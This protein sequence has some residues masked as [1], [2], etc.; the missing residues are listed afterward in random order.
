MNIPIY[1]KRLEYAEKEDEKEFKALRKKHQA[2]SNK[3]NAQGNLNSMFAD[4]SIKAEFRK[5][6]DDMRMFGAGLKG[7]EMIIAHI[8][9]DLNYLKGLR[10][11]AKTLVGM[12]EKA[13]EKLCPGSTT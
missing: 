5:G 3:I 1:E 9:R 13:K 11:G 2:F 12:V 10:E 4:I 6:K 8:K 7:T